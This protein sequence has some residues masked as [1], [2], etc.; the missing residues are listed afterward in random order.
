V[1]SRADVVERVG[2][3]QLTEEVIEKDYVLGWLLW[4][5]AT[6]RVVAEQWVFKGGTCLK[7]WLHRDVP[8]LGRSRLH[9][10]ARGSDPA[11]GR[12]ASARACA[13]AR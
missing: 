6:D 10:L 12:R 13:S 3:W 8:L 11:R 1:I 5:I 2:E 7:K 4:G 9:G